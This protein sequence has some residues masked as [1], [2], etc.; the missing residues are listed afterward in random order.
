MKTPDAAIEKLLSAYSP[1]IQTLALRVREIILTQAPTAAEKANPG[2]RSI[3]F[4]HPEVGY[5]C[6]L[7]L[8]E[9][10][11]DLAFEFGVLL[12]DP[13]GLLTSEAAQV[14]YLRVRTMADAPA[15]QVGEL[16]EAAINLPADRAT[17]I[18][19]VK[20]GARPFEPGQSHV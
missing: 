11:V 3:N 1:E 16:I 2:W 8:S 13:D 5:F 17:R 12:P 18:Q 19:M 20:S 9:E 4:S 6:G 10:G 7:F 15:Q 14:R